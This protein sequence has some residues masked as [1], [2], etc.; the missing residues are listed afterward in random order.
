MDPE[1]GQIWFYKFTPFTL[2]EDAI[3]IQSDL[4]NLKY[5]YGKSAVSLREV[6]IWIARFSLGKEDTTDNHRAERPVT[7]TDEHIILTYV[8]ATNWRRS[9]YFNMRTKN[10][11]WSF[12]WNHWKDHPWTSPSENVLRKVDAPSA[13]R[14][15]EETE[16]GHV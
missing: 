14:R 2:G 13:D 10:K 1:L 8:S 7:V 6:Y 4:T 5:I 3:R 11:M 9:T 16:Y 12:T 15:T